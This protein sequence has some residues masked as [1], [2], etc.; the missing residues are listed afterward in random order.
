MLLSPLSD[1]R[2][3]QFIAVLLSF[4]AGTASAQ[5]ASRLLAADDI[6]SVK[7]VTDPQFSP[8]GDWVAYTVRTGDYAKDKRSVHAPSGVIYS[9]AS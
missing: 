1:S 5:P 9:T 2:M 3:R 8:D 4:L 7:T 6:T